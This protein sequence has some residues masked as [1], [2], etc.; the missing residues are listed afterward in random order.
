MFCIK[1]GFFVVSGNYGMLR[2]IN[3]N[4]CNYLYMNFAVIS[5][6]Y[7]EI[8]F[9]GGLWRK[10]GPDWRQVINLRSIKKY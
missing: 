7:G 5:I 6:F 4:C 3:R 2:R 10:F 9:C 1:V 8:C